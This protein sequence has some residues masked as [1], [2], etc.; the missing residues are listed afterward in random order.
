MIPL[1]YSTSLRQTAAVIIK[2]CTKCLTSVAAALEAARNATGEV[3]ATLLDADQ[4]VYAGAGSSYYL[5][6]AAAWAHRE[7][8]GTAAT[9]APLSELILRPTGVIG[10]GPAASRPLVVISRSGS[11]SEAVAVAEG[12][13]PPG[14][15]SWP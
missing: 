4:V 10:A 3:A 15:R 11:T 12:G 14:I 5:A 1:K 7:L 8:L 13:P 6:Q 2:K 9:A